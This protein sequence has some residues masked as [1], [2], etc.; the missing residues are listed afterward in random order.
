LCAF[1]D[2][3]PDELVWWQEEAQLPM[4]QLENDISVV[5]P[6]WLLKQQSQ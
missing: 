3:H 2:A 1:F 6:R 4:V 5:S